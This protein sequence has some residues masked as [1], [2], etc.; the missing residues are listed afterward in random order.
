ML[1]LSSA[2]HSNALEVHLANNMD[3]R[4]TDPELQY[5]S[6]GTG[7]RL[8]HTHSGCIWIVMYIYRITPEKLYIPLPT[9]GH[10]NCGFTR[11]IC[12]LVLPVVDVKA[13]PSREIHPWWRSRPPAWL[14]FWQAHCYRSV[15][16]RL[17]NN[18]E[19]LDYFIS[20][21]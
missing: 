3:R 8:Q 9:Y 11:C 13:V 15:Q 4:R 18:W 10:Q 2:S 19:I 20:S 17:A 6:H 16:T 12:H 1:R 5:W 21:V 7:G 14:E